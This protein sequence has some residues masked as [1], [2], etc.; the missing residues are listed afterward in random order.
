VR[1]FSTPRGALLLAWN[2]EMGGEERAFQ[3]QR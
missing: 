3:L 2:V 1:R